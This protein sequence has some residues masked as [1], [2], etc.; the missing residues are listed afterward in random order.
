MVSATM[1]EMQEW[2]NLS[3][4]MLKLTAAQEVR[5]VHSLTGDGAKAA[6]F[7]VTSGSATRSHVSWFIWASCVIHI[8]LPLLN[9]CRTVGG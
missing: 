8:L 7:C 4:S 2:V 9:W 5:Y 6:K 1:G 3:V